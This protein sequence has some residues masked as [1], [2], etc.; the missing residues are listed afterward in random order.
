LD[1]ALDVLG[2]SGK[3]AVLDELVS[4]QIDWDKDDNSI[5]AEIED[6]LKTNFK[7]G[8]SYLISRFREELARG[9]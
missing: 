5:I 1:R 7:K 6:F 3:Q 2:T 8:S 4:R 9:E